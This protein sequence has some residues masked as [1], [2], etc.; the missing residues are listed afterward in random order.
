METDHGKVEYWDELALALP[1]I[2]TLSNIYPPT[3]RGLR[4]RALDGAYALI[5]AFSQREKENSLALCLG[6]GLPCS[7]LRAILNFIRALPRLKQRISWN[8]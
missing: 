7:C 6:S 2:S 5:P 8:L 4:V 1:R 3:G